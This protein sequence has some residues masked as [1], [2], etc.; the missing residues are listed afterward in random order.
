[1]GLTRIADTSFLLAVYNHKD[2][3]H[4]QAFAWLENP[5]SIAIPFEVLLETVGVAQRRYGFDI[6]THIE[7]SLRRLPHI[8]FLPPL[9]TS[10]VRVRWHAAK[11]RLSWV[12]AAVVEAC[13]RRE[14]HA[15]TFDPHIHAETES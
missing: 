6:A 10:T 15:L 9:D 7:Q 13:R 2:R 14:G 3:F 5:D 1:L 11:G 4:E 12:D 8:S